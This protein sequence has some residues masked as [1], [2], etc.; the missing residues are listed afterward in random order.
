LY[1]KIPLCSNALSGP[2]PATLTKNYSSAYA[3]ASFCPLAT[4][5]AQEALCWPILLVFG[6][7]LGAMFIVGR[8][9]LQSFDLTA[10]RFDRGRQY[11]MRNINVAVQVSPITDLITSGVSDD[12]GKKVIP[13]IGDIKPL[14]NI[15][16]SISKF[17]EKGGQNLGQ[18]LSGL[19]PVRLTK[20]G[21]SPTSGKDASKTPGLVPTVNM[22]GGLSGLSPQRKGLAGIS[23]QPKGLAS[24]SPQRPVLAGKFPA[25]SGGKPGTP[26]ALGGA[27]S[28]LSN[29]GPSPNLTNLGA[30]G[31]RSPTGIGAFSVINPGLSTI[32]DAL[33]SSGPAKTNA[34][35]NIK[36]LFTVDSSQRVTSLGNLLSR[37]ATQFIGMSDV[38]PF[39]FIVKSFASGTV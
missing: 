34:W 23:P 18:I 22:V 7:L 3:E 21:D 24:L 6:M 36:S 37:V 20:V 17:F 19:S 2:Q 5:N 25:S 38:G 32:L 8:N 39:G 13:G 35:N 11:Q 33:T 31:I 4:G 30:T 16:T 14:K 26:Q 29:T 12:K 1:N 28:Q 9:P 15:T 27:F 10:P